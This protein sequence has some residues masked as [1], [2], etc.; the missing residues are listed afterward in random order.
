MKFFAKSG[1]TK[2]ELYIYDDIGGG[3]FSEGIT[4]QSIADALKEFTPKVA[5]DV[6]IN[7][8]GGSVFEGVAIYNQLMRWNGKK[9][10]HI[11]GIAASIASVIAMCGDEINMAGNGLMMIHRAWG[12]G[13][14]TSDD[15][16]KT[17]EALDKIDGVILDTYTSRTGGD[18]AQIEKWMR[19]ETWMNADEA[20]ERGFATKKTEEKA[21]KAS[22]PLLAKFKNTPQT[23]R[24]EGLE[25]RGLV[26]RMGMRTAQLNRGQAPV[27]A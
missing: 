16:R 23:L 3:F 11:D 4:A 5:I 17:G 19:D 20:V 12:L 22:F 9:M 6:Y 24:R 25:S 15:M 27:R 2:N 1:G 10:V 26:A 8:P 21:I 13:M 7:S 14:G 18:R